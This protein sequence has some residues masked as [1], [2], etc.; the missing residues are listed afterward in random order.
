MNRC[1]RYSLLLL[2]PLSL[3]ARESPDYGGYRPHYQGYGV[4]TPGGRGG[5]IIR[6]TNLNDRGP[7]SLR[8]AL[9]AS[10]RR[11]VL[12]ETSG[13][14]VLDAPICITSPFVTVAG[15]TAPSP[16]IAL[17]R[18]PIMIDTHDVVL[19]HLRLRQGDE[20]YKP[21]PLGNNASTLYVRND[22]TN[23]VLDHLSLSW[24]NWTQLGLNH[25]REPGWTDVTVV[26]CLIAYALEPARQIA[27]ADH[28]EK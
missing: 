4:G 14:I 16:G 11:V 18:H 28:F 24:G 20:A 25:W 10:G 21:A 15:Q 6:V 17:R 23:V 1:A 19:Q 22:A 9:E 8:A 13:T 5:D 27:T 2:L 26:D 3:V 7:G 12:F